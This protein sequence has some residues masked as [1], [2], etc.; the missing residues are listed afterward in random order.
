R[1]LGSPAKKAGRPGAF[2]S[3]R[4]KNSSTTK[5]FERP[6]PL[7]TARERHHLHLWT[8]PMKAG[9]FNVWVGT[10]NLDTVGRA[11]RLNVPFHQIDPDVDR[12][13]DGLALDLQQSPCLRGSS[14]IAVTGPVK[15]ENS[16]HSPFFSDGNAQ[17]LWIDCRADKI[18]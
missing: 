16:A 11:T 5:T 6:T 18:E 7:G 1:S 12:Q 9:Q 17:E 2:G 8:T 14:I 4:F 13:R 15:G 10:V 3:G